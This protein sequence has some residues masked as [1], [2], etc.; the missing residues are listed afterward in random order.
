MEVFLGFLLI[1]LITTFA[2]DT[3]QKR[4]RYLNECRQFRTK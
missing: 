3:R 2:V 4:R 1:S